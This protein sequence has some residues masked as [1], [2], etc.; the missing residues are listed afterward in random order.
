MNDTSEEDGIIGELIK[1]RKLLEEKPA[2]K[3]EGL[4]E[5]FMDFL[6]KYKVMGLAVAFIIGIYVGNLVHALVEDLLMPLIGLVVP[7]LGELISFSLTIHNQ[8]FRIGDFL[9][10]L[11]TFILVAFVIFIMVKITKK[12]GIS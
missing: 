2:R 8:V 5:E 7:S 6:S 3:P 11:L 10:A 4:W 12:W 1:I 9:V